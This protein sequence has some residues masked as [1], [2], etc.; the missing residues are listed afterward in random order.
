MRLFML[1]LGCKPEGRH[2]EQHDIYFGVAKK[3]ADL[4]PEMKAFWPEAGTMHVD[5]WRHI[6]VVDEYQ[7]QIVPIT[8]P[9]KPSKKKLFFVNLGGYVAESMEE[10][11]YKQL[12]VATTLGKAAAAAKKT[13]FYKTH[14]SPHI[15][16]QYGLDVDDIYAVEDLL[17]PDIKAQ[18]RIEITPAKALLKADKLHIGYL[19]FVDLEQR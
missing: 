18:Y 13:K 10:F 1:M 4:V 8:T 7:V 14:I 2:T 9:A 19:K 11:H 3:L 6:K 15:D 12:V 16:D 17:S 5:V